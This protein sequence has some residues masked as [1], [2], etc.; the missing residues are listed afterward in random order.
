[1]IVSVLELPVRAGSEQ[2][3]IEFYVEHE[4]FRLAGEGLGFRSG[5]LLQP[6]EPDG[7]FI[8]V[9][10]WDD[11]EA[12]G[13]WLE[14]PSRAELSAELDPLLDGAPSGRIYEVVNRD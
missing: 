1:V 5:R 2:A 3:V 6:T 8:V 10:E 4:V 9:A 11:A 12:Y 7:A 13:R 14:S